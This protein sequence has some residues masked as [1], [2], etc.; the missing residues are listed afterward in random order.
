[1]NMQQYN[2]APNIRG[3]FS[4]HNYSIMT[5]HPTDKGKNNTQFKK[6][7]TSLSSKNNTASAS[8]SCNSELPHPELVKVSLQSFKDVFNSTGCGVHNSIQFYA[9]PF[10]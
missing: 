10:R 6:D 9:D 5:N 8:V 3:T 4:N 2:C 1:M 7:D